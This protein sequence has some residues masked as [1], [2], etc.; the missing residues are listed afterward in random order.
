MAHKTRT[1][2]STEKLTVLAAFVFVAGLLCASSPLMV[3]AALLVGLRLSLHLL[4]FARPVPAHLGK[5]RPRV[6]Y[7]R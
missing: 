7:S 4:D 2:A 1:S 6:R 5:E 3:L